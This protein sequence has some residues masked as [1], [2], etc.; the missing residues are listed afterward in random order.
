MKGIIPIGGRGT[1]M[2][3]VTYSVNKHFIPV[4]NRLLIEYPIETITQTGIKEIGITHNP[5]QLKMA[6]EVLGDGSRWGAKFTYILQK[7]PL[8]LAN[9]VE[10]VEEFVDGDSFVFHLG[11]NIFTDGIV[12]LVDKF[13]R[14]NWDGMVSK[15]EHEENRRMGVPYFD[16]QGRL[17]K[18][19]E[20]PE[21]PPHKFAV[22]GVY[23]AN[24]KIFGAFEGKDRIKPSDRGEYEI[25]DLFQW[26]IDKGMKVGVEEYKGLWLDPGKFGDWLESNQILLDR[27]VVRHIDG[28]VDSKSVIKGRVEIGEGSKII[29]SKIR[30][31]VRIGENV[32][33]KNSFIG[34]YTSIYNQS[35]VEGSRVENTVV[36]GEVEMEKV[37]KGID[38]SIIGKN[39][40]VAGNG[41]KGVMELFVGSGGVL[42]L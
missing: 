35:R 3:P 10:V 13:K 33:V 26:M 7:E 42:K 28:E 8:G 31:P 22:P 23:L 1:R 32:I 20:K 2:R 24:A 36:M 18:Y 4:A 34:P 27:Y 11:D 38:A 16:K 17:Q 15:L 5:G 29:D 40:R 30:G 25:A 6:K 9:I 41:R 12:D 14:E 37:S 21:N 39:A 19:V